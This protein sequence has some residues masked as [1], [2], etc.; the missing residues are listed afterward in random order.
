MKVIAVLS[1]VLFAAFA[2]AGPA[3]EVADNSQV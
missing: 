1:A 3:N 2:V